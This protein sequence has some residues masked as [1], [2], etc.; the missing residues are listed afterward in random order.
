LDAYGWRIA[1]LLGAVTLPF[2]LWLRRSLP[3]TLD[4]LETGP[5]KPRANEGRLATAWRYRRI[6]VAGVVV[7][8]GGTIG[9]YIFQYIATYAQATLH[10]PATSGFASEFVG[11]ALSIGSALLGGSLSDRVGRR[12]VIIWGNLALLILIYPVF[13]WITVTRSVLALVVGVA[14]LTIL[15]C[16]S[17]G[18]FCAALCES[19]PKSVRA[20]VF[21]VVFA[22][23]ITVFGGTTQLVVTWLIHVTGDPMAPAWYLIGATAVAQVARM[24]IP[25][26][27]PAKLAVHGAIVAR[28]ALSATDSDL[29]LAP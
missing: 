25:E 11:Y 2:G 29:G 19:L 23:S 6:I 13:L 18:A 14:I 24:L 21:A 17:G 15:V 16:F 12:P 8:G 20:S 7:F 10:M 4:A 28:P 1:F 5:P 9:T 3:E 27:A 26:S 22:L